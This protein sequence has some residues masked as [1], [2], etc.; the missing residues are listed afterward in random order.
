MTVTLAL[1]KEALH[2]VRPLVLADIGLPP[3]LWARLGL[4]VPPLFADGRL[5]VVAP[6][7]PTE[8]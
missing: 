6:A 3:V 5:L 4:D 2:S 8:A 1:P 7:Q